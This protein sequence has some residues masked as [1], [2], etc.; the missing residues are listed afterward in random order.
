MSKTF[1]DVDH[2]LKITG[3]GSLSKIRRMIKE[4]SLGVCIQQAMSIYKEINETYYKALA[5]DGKI[6]GSERTDI[7]EWIDLFFD[8]LIMTWKTLEKGNQ[9]TLI[10]IENKKHHFSLIILEKN[11]LWIV[12]GH[13]TPIMVSPVK[14]F[15]EIY[16]KQLSPEII[17]LLQTYRAAVADK[18]IDDQE[19]TELQSGLKQVLYYTLFL[20]LQLEKCLIND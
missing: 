2:E 16:N 19:K 18:V 15:R 20:R 9:E 17:S 3:R 10:K 6:I 13:L 12:T 5:N 1:F 11:G 14:N 8:L 7:L 4:P